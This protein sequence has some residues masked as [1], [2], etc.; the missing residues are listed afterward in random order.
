M[1][2]EDFK[3]IKD[4]HIVE[5]ALATLYQMEDSPALKLQDEVFKGLNSLTSMPLERE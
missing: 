3:T 5:C 1:N 4:Y 2:R